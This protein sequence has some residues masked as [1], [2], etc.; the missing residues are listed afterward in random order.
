MPEINA[1]LCIACH[2]GLVFSLGCKKPLQ[3]RH[4]F[5]LRHGVVSGGKGESENTNTSCKLRMIP[6]IYKIL[7]VLVLIRLSELFVC[8]WTQ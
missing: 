8:I 1:D 7:L 4:D 3:W 2:A 5:K 6:L